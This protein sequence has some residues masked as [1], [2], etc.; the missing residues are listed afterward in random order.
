ME[1]HACCKMQPGSDNVDL[2]LKVTS[3]GDKGCGPKDKLTKKF[4]EIRTLEDKY[5]V[6]CNKVIEKGYCATRTGG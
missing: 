2:R 3:V 6:D 5:E 4:I 1:Y